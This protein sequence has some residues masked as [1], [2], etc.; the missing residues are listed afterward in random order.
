MLNSSALSW[1]GGQHSELFTEFKSN[2][3]RAQKLHGDQDWIW[4]LHNDKIKFFP[5]IWIQSYKWEIRSRDE[6][7]RQ[8][9]KFVFNTV[10]NPTGDP[11]T[12]VLAFHGTPNPEDV[13]DPIIVDNWQ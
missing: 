4:H 8:G 6:L 3:A 5:E 9:G 2:P 11:Q 1:I 7:V 13:M 12:N 10:K